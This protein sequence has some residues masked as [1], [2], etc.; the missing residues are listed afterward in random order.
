MLNVKHGSCEYH[1]LKSFGQTQPGNQLRSVHYEE[2]ALTTRAQKHFIF[3]MFFTWL[4]FVKLNLGFLVY[5]KQ[6]IIL[7]KFKHFFYAIGTKLQKK[8]VIS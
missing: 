7:T 8:D 4:W 3:I 1:I 6:R 2:G 5:A